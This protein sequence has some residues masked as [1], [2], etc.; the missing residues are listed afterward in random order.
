MAGETEKWCVITSQW[1]L[2]AALLCYIFSIPNDLTQV[3]NFLYQI[4][5]WDSTVLPFWISFTPLGNFDH[6]VFS[7]SIDFP[8]NLKQGPLLHCIAHDYF[9]VDW[10]HLR[11][12]LWEDIFE[13][14]ASSSVIEFC[15][16]FEVGIDVYIP[17]CKYHSS[18][19]HLN[20][21]QLLLLLP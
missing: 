16:W 5:D 4:R 10:D 6:V 9:C 11:I 19:T 14:R 12:V 13:L 15:E 18:H 20:G 2:F 8:S 7:V 17:H 3:V 1:P 21:F